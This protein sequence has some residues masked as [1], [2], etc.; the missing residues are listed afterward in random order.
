MTPKQRSSRLCALLLQYILPFQDDRY[1]FNYQ[2]A[3]A[4]SQDT[5][6]LPGDGLITECTYSTQER[7]KPTLG[8]YSTREEMCLSFVL[9]YPRTELAGCYSIPPVKYFFENLGVKEFYG[10]TMNEVER[11]LL[12]GK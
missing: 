5:T 6:I 4:L 10:K 12:E 3:R 9:Y 7:S 2:Q 11:V 1:D 8:G